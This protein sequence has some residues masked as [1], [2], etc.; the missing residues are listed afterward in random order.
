MIT[1]KF[2]GA[3]GADAVAELG[4]RSCPDILVNVIPIAFVIANFLAGSAD[5]QKTAQ[6]FYFAY[7]SLE[8]DNGLIELF[9]Q[10]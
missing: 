10:W 4:I 1:I 3:I 6:D 2:P 7:G 8:I 9:K 5:R